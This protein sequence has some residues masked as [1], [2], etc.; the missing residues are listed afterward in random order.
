MD[1]TKSHPEPEGLF[2]QPLDVLSVGLE[3]F[4]ADL[5]AQGVQVTALDWKPPADADPDLADILSKLGS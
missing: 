3:G 5:Q 2:D 1:N 4:A